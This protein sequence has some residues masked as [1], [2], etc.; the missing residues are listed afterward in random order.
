MTIGS[1]VGKPPATQ[2]SM[3]PVLRSIR[4][5]DSVWRSK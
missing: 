4:F 1:Q 3:I 2:R 5:K